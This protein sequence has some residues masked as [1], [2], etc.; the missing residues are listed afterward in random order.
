[1]Q[2]VREQPRADW[3]ARVQKLGFE[4][5]TMHGRP[6][7]DESASYRF[8]ASEID[9]L[10][11][12]TNELHRL[13][14]DA[15]DHVVRR[16]R[17]A[18][19][20][21]PANFHPF[22][23]RSW[24]DREAEIYG[25]FDLVY[26]GSEPQLLEYNADTPTSLLEASVVQWHW[27]KDVHPRADQFNSIHERLI[28]TWRDAATRHPL[29]TVHFASVHD[30]DED[31]ITCTYMRDVCTQAGFATAE[32]DVPAIGWSGRDFTDLD[33]RPIRRLFKLYPWEWLVRE[34]FGAH[35]LK[36]STEFIEPAW[37]MLL[38][39]KALLP[40]LWELNPGHPNLL[41]AYRSPERLGSTYVRKPILGREGANVT[42]MREGIGTTTPG[43][44]GEEGHI[45][46]ALQPLPTFDGNHVVIGSWVIGGRAA[47][48]GIREDT[49]P[50]TGNL[51][52]FVPHWFK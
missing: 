16:R 1:M 19:F 32:I 42:I 27:L 9:R 24:Q 21:I 31:R 30:S 2:R 41:P 28:E 29:A 4:F 47:G 3:V 43:G 52:R 14:L 11:D 20:S 36:Q 8:S 12:A 25:R 45:Y 50:V 39:N 13:C 37:K 18:E 46:Q 44:Y 34:E 40:I 48:L 23:E 22:I 5:H 38:S 49:N 51:S 7:W 26:D 15:V 6:Y 17:F 10:E 35:I 33:E